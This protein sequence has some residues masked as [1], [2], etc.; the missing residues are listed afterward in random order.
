MK[1]TLYHAKLFAHEL[2]QTHGSDDPK[3]FIATV[4]D[5]QVNLTPHQIDAALFAFQS[6]LSKGAVLADEV[7]LGKTIE[8]G[9][10]LSQKWAER[11]R[12]ILVIC[13]ANLRKQ[14]SQELADK[15]FLPSLILEGKQYKREKKTGK[16]NPFDNRDH[17]LICSFQ[18][19]AGKQTEVMQVGWDLVVIDEAHRLRNV[20]KNANRTG[21]ALKTALHNVPKILL[22]ATPLQNSLLELYGLVS[23]IDEHIFGDL[24]SFKAQFA[25]LSDDDSFTDLKERIE[26]VVQRTLRRQVLEYVS[27]TARHAMV[28]PYTPY[29]DEQMLYEGVSAYLQRDRL[30]ALPVQQRQLMTLILRKLL[31]SSSFAVSAT[32][33]RLETRLRLLLQEQSTTAPLNFGADDYDAYD[34]TAEEWGEETPPEAVLSEADLTLVSEESDELRRLKELALSI[35]KNAKGDKLMTA[36]QKGFE[37]IQELGGARKA[38]I[39]T[40]SRRTQNYLYELLENNGYAGESVL[41]NGQNNDP[42]SKEIYYDWMSANADTDRISGAKAADIRAA[43]V[44]YFRNDAT[45]L[46]ATEAASEG[47]NLQFCSFLVNFDLPW[48]PQRIEQRIGR[49]HRYGQKHDVVVLNFLNQNNA[50]D[51]RVYDLLSQ[52]FQLFEGVFGASDEVLGSLENGVD[53]EKRIVDIYQRCREPEEIKQAFDELQNELE[54]D[55]ADTMKNTRRKLLENFDL[56]VSHKLKMRHEEAKRY[57]NAYEE[58]LWNLTRWYL[59]DYAEFDT[60]AGA[61]RLRRNPFP[62]API[63]NGP[64]RMGERSNAAN[65]YRVHHP[66]AR[67]ILAD[68][69]SATTPLAALRFDYSG[70]T[71]TK[72]SALEPYVGQSGWLQIDLLTVTAADEEDFLLCAALTDDG[73]TV[74]PATA[75]QLFALPAE[76]L[77]LS[78]LPDAVKN[79]LAARTDYLAQQEINDLAQR[80]GDLFDREMEKYDKWAEDCKRSLEKSIDDLDNSIQLKKAEA[81]K[82]T[83]LQEKIKAQREVKDLEK[84]RKDKRQNLYEE[85]DRISA[86]KEALLDKV[87]AALTQQT[88]REGV[89]LVR[90]EVV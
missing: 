64:Y 17:I 80:N 55:I 18:F 23:F 65:V 63:H 48:N 67:H 31:A 43:I 25:R 24:R 90:W 34:E 51:Q 58:K 45:I 42:K 12:R 83:D 56:E 26:P 10:I 40:E 60:E 79:D 28:E 84:R 30:F 76:V 38:I 68:C 5:A 73:E 22:T 19:A 1:L 32:L 4:S 82:L 54:D 46:I 85:Q 13:P 15:F 72:I 11:K 36:L 8:A 81:R 47:I 62:D 44:D 29:D 14:W 87:Q 70:S 33:T 53:F 41:F 9:I 66:L 52:K 27:Y 20:Y 3:K 16:D 35:R 89:F 78:A 21:R 6:P 74:D 61:F 37:R 75:Q 69:Q 7:G 39:F 50:A 2:L 49:V 86:K 71:R 88:T 57:L 77:P 59:A